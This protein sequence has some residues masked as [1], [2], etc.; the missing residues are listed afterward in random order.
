MGASS[1]PEG[2]EFLVLAEHIYTLTAGVAITEWVHLKESEIYKHTANSKLG[3]QGIHSIVNK[4]GMDIRLV[5]YFDNIVYCDIFSKI[6]YR[7]IFSNIAIQ[8]FPISYHN[9]CHRY[10]KRA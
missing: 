4:T 9:N 5:R 6:V 10:C 2:R 7:D 8:C 3:L 1:T